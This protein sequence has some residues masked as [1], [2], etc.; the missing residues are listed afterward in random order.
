[1]KGSK[2]EVGGGPSKKPKTYHFHL[3]W[4]EDL[5]FFIMKIKVFLLITKHEEYNQLNDDHQWLNLAFSTDLTSKL[6][7]HDLGNFQNLTSDL[8]T[9]QKSCVQL[10]H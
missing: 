5:L 2:N 7:L 1:M 9:Q 10:D 4:E 8:V 6:Q 3:E